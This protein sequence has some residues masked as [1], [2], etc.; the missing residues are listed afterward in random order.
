MPTLTYFV[1][2]GATALSA[3]DRFSGSS[4]PPL[5]NVGLKQAQAAAARVADQPIVAVYCSPLQRARQ[6]A[7]A[8][9]SSRNLTPVSVDGLREIDHGH[10]EGLEQD[11]VKTRFADEHARWSADPFGFAP[12]GGE[13]GLSV[14]NRSLPALRDIVAR[15][16]NQTVALVSHKATIR[17]LACAL[18]G[19]DPHRYR[20]RLSLELAS[21][22]LF[23]FESFERPRLLLWNER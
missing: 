22:S 14:L 23:S 15:H 13:P 12:I 9:A 11:D 8:I 16:A 4:D 7:Q 6:T 18:L 1:R 19:I 21:V 10:W 5:S 17:L 20:D 2:H 3:E